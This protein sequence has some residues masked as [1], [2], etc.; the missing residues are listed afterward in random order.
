MTDMHDLVG[1]YATDALDDSQRA[2]FERHLAGC[3]RC[4][5]ELA[6]YY[7][8]LAAIADTTATVPPAAAWDAVAHSLHGADTEPPNEG[9][10]PTPTDADS[11]PS[12]A[13]TPM[14]SATAL[15]W[16]AAAAVAAVLFA[17]GVLV[18]RQTV[19]T[20]PV[21]ADAGTSSVLAVAAAADAQFTD[22]ELMGSRSRV[23]TSSEMDTSVFLA[24]DLPTP[25][26]GMCYQ[27]WRVNDDGSKE[28]AG[29]FVPD[30]DGHVAVT[31]D[32]GADVTSYV[33]TLEPP[34][35][36]KTPTGEMVAQVG[37]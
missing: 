5:D 27:V 13:A 16:L 37:A 6:G 24:A 34:G 14:R 29:V 31:L 10:A 35:G 36:S 21:V 12:S 26:K 17:G 1:A 4:A 22:V 9:P 3:A 19:P 28:S 33:I 20:S 23:V 15:R 25:A 2:E 30:A 18:G 8:V 11:E 32:G 7:E